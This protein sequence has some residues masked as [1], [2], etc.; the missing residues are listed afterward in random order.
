MQTQEEPGRAWAATNGKRVREVWVD[1]LSAWSDVKRPEFDKAVSAVLAGHVPI[2]WCAF[3]DWAPRHLDLLPMRWCA[4]R[5][6]CAGP[7]T[8]TSARSATASASPVV[9]E[10]DV[11]GMEG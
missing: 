1:N 5:R 8:T 6:G 7:A 4:A 9:T 2:L 10:C 11:D 3:L